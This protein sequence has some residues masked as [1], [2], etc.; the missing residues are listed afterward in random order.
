MKQCKR[1]LHRKPKSEFCKSSRLKD[2]LQTWCKQ[3]INEYKR[4]RRTK[5]RTPEQKAEYKRRAELSRLALA[6]LKRCTECK[7]IKP[8]SEFWRGSSGV[9]TNTR[10]RCAECQQRINQANYGSK[11]TT[12]SSRKKANKAVYDAIQRGDIT[13]PSTCPLCEY[14]PPE[15]ESGYTRIQFHHTDGYDDDSIFTGVFACARC[16][17][18][19]HSG[20]INVEGKHWL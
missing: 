14:N 8:L 17:S 13:R 18:R 1:C 16:H 10:G 2:G 15:R 9:T 4:E 7:E 20:E 6:S 5:S 3:C 12:S 19:I 11:L